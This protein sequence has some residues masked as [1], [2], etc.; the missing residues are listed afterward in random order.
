MMIPMNV[1][2]D[3]LFEVTVVLAQ[4]EDGPWLKEGTAKASYASLFLIRTC[5]HCSRRKRSG[6]SQDRWREGMAHC[7]LHNESDERAAS[8]IVLRSRDLDHSVPAVSPACF[9][10]KA[11]ALHLFHGPLDSPCL[12]SALPLHQKP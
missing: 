1:F 2:D 8:A 4:S 6:G 9:F 12:H 5:V 7:S 11:H 3:E 10:I